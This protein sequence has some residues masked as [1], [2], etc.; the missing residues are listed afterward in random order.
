MYAVQFCVWE[1]SCVCQQ[2]GMAGNA[3]CKVYDHAFLY[4][5]SI[6]TVQHTYDC[7]RH[8]CL[9]YT[10]QFCPW[11]RTVSPTRCGRHCLL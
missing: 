3:Y 5:R 1:T 2:V 7:V 10:V 11:E 4:G 8:P 6:I 9:M